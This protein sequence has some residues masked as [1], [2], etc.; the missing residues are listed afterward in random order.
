M[1]E[2]GAAVTQMV[3]LGL[4]LLTGGSYYCT[5]LDVL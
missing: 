1:A 5:N 3:L 4:A 2:S